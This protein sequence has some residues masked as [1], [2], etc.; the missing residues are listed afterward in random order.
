MILLFVVFAVICGD[1]GGWWME[2]WCEKRGLN[3]SPP[4]A[5]V[6]PKK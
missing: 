5:Q 4:W 2:V 6:V 3:A 1:A